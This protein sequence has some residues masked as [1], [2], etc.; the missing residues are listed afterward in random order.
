MLPLFGPYENA[1]LVFSP[2]PLEE[3]KLND[4]EENPPTW[5]P[6]RHQMM[7]PK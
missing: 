4:M 1:N 6:E 7:V 2:P 3:F 5:R